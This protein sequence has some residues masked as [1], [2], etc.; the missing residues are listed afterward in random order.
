MNRNTQNLGFLI[1][2]AKTANGALPIENALVYIYKND[3]ENNDVLYSL[4]TDNNGRTQKIA[5]ET[6]DKNLSMSPGNEIPFSTY[7]IVIRA[8]GYYY[9]SKSNVPVFEGI[10]S[11]QTA[12]L[13]PLSEYADPNSQNPDSIGRYLNT[14]NTEL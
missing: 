11:I 2:E 5:L 10:T 7:N 4:R 12:N 3:T 9:S 13:I 1:V 6:K 14:P 8:D